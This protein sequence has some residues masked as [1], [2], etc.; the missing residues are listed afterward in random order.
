MN[1][2]F[3]H[4]HWYFDEKIVPQKS[5]YYGGSSSQPNEQLIGEAQHHLYFYLV[6]DEENG[7]DSVSHQDLDDHG[8]FTIINH[9]EYGTNAHSHSTPSKEINNSMFKFTTWDGQPI[10]DY[11]ILSTLQKQFWVSKS[12]ICNYS[13]VL[14][15]L[16]N[17]HEITS[18]S[19]HDGNDDGGSSSILLTHSVMNEHLLLM[20]SSMGDDHCN[21]IIH[22]F[23][24]LLEFIHTGSLGVPQVLYVSSSSE[25][26]H[27]S[28]LE[29]SSCDYSKGEL[30]E[31]IPSSHTIIT[32]KD[33]FQLLKIAD[34]FQVTSL[35][36]A[37][38]NTVN[39]FNALTIA[40]MCLHSLQYENSKNIIFNQAMDII[41]NHVECILSDHVYHNIPLKRDDLILKFSHCHS[42]D[43]FAQCMEDEYPMIKTLSSKREV[44]ALLASMQFSVHARIIITL[45]VEI[46]RGIFQSNH[47]R[48]AVDQIAI[49]ISMWT[50]H[51]FQH[52][53][54]YGV[55]LLNEFLPWL[56]CSGEILYGVVFNIF[57][58]MG[59]ELHKDNNNN[60]TRSSSSSMDP[61]VTHN[62][63]PVLV[64]QDSDN[65]N[66]L[67]T[68]IM[69]LKDHLL[70]TLFRL[71]NAIS[72]DVWEKIKFGPHAR[73]CNHHHQQQHHPPFKTFRSLKEEPRLLLL[74]LDQS[75]KTSLLYKLTLGEI[76]TTIPT[77]GFNVE[78]LF[79]EN[80]DFTVWD[81]GGQEK[82][83]PLWRHYYER[84]DCVIFVI[85]S[86]DKDR[87]QEAI[88]ELNRVAHAKDLENV[89]ILIF[90]NKID[91]PQAVPCSEVSKLLDSK[92][93]P[94]TTNYFIQPLSVL[95]LE[96][97]EEGMKWILK[98]LQI[99][100]PKKVMRKGVIFG[101]ISSLSSIPSM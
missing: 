89:P 3:D 29:K 38:R 58:Q 35:L 93:L 92:P 50:L 15:N 11:C 21:Q 53:Y 6:R 87:L 64:M 37:I 65:R 14:A 48:L 69:D 95:T 9:F 76:V 12:A 43:D 23:K 71:Q 81:V 86:S 94:S 55:Q 73:S 85:D 18:S 47:C 63:I 45:P 74:G 80:V 101:S 90:V 57:I 100:P 42:L 24:L 39:E 88:D 46:L 28:H 36:K 72:D 67:S 97:F 19:H 31:S 32:M 82:I 68:M 56:K 83:R 2:E 99:Q 75:G 13:S 66:K 51:D 59:K 41:A 22:Y 20:T 79:Y 26:M 78:T 34:Y 84:T 4:S 77:I 27:D 96:G 40:L 52:R 61:N 44:C 60:T 54:V 7:E 33:V 49:L 30:V 16:V 10:Q 8:E 91:R 17:T 1:S 70:K 5:I 98:T 25:K 62:S